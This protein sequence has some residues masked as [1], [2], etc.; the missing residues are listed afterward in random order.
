MT[1]TLPSVM[2]SNMRD[3]LQTLAG[4][5]CTGILVLFFNSSTAATTGEAAASITTNGAWCWFADP[6]AVTRD[7]RTYTGWVTSDGSVQAAM[8][9]HSS[10]KVT[11][12]D[13]HA[14][15][16]R[17]DHDNP[18]F[19]F[20]PD[21]RLMTFYSKHVG[22]EMNMRLTKHPGDITEW[23]FERNLDLYGGERPRR[24]ITYSHP[25]ML[26]DE[27]NAI[28]LF[29]RGDTWKPTFSKSTDLGKTWTPNKVV[30]SRTGAGDG[31]RP[32]VKIA[33]N[34]KDRIHM[35]FTDGHPRDERSNSVYYAY[36]KNGAFFKADGTRIAGMDELPF[37]PE[38]ADL[39]YD[40]RKTNVR[41][42]LWEVAEDRD[43]KPVIVYT[44]LPSERDHRYH[45]ARWNGK[46]WTDTELCESGGW[47]PQTRAGAN[48]REPHYSPG[49]ALDHS[50]PAVLYVS[51]PVNG[52]REIE[53]WTTGN[54]GDSWKIEA[55]T[56]NSKNDNVRP[57]VVRN[58][59]A[60][61]P[62]V[63]WMNLSGHY[64]H[65]TNYLTSIKCDKPAKAELV[66]RSKPALSTELTR[67]AVLTAM[68]RVGDWVLNNPT[69]SNPSRSGTRGWTYGALDAGIMALTEV[70]K[71]PAYREAM[72][73][74]GEFHKWRLGPRKYH[75]DDHVIGQ[76]YVEL[77]LTTRDPKMIAPMKE[78]FDSILATPRNFPSLDFTQRGI[79][80]LWSWCDALFMAPPAWAR[81]YTATGDKKYLDFAVTN[82]WRTS[83]YL[84]DKTE[85]LYF[86]DSTFFE[87][88]EANGKKIFWSRGN[89]WVMGGLVR[90]LQ[91]LPK[92]H[93]DRPRF[94]QQLKEMSA[95]LLRCQQ[96]D[97]LWR[98][99]LLD[100][101]H[102]PLQ[103]TSG[104][105]FHTYAIAWGVN[106][107]LLDRATYEPVVRK[108]WPALVA[109]VTPEGRVT[110]VQ[111]I[112]ADPRRFDPNA[113]ETYG[114]GAFLLAGSEVY[115]MTNRE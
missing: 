54:G 81:L 78:Q 11:I 70:S 31:N 17:D 21:G 67:S 72:M 96:P 48:E 13:L 95:A 25:A 112:G 9:E 61:G 113:T 45:Y 27:S 20:L 64:V 56:A 85:Q 6:R 62:T 91:H 43:G 55:V 15:Y 89:G 80:D 69:L 14:R 105:S 37:A 104:S 88:R 47:F 73:Q 51:R 76:T 108:A 32:Y 12:T 83:D 22:P 114:I 8:L 26:S 23:E 63:L 39:V 75:G 7:G 58:H 59:T 111:P 16:E 60:D 30:V 97:G 1:D 28:Y 87:K 102:Y 2:I 79:D 99:S 66:V 101:E 44:R 34:N 40:A 38:R 106:K 35:I 109:S 74:M 84:Y 10:G 92:D 18:S 98:S 50:N 49:I 33:S 19:L 24:N 90:M 42:W 52:I 77:F 41:A 4:V 100:P 65:Y 71:K 94:E 29:W 86:R 57:F 93:P 5:V 46:E 82:W 107:G 36:Y 68:E 110:H 53:R 115:R 103:E 3:R